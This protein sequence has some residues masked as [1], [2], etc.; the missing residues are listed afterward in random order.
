MVG[1]KLEFR[2]KMLGASDLVL[3]TRGQTAQLVYDTAKAMTESSGSREITLSGGYRI[4]ITT[5]Y[6]PP[7]MTWHLRLLYPYGHIDGPIMSRHATNDVLL[8]AFTYDILEE[9]E[10]L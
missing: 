1:P 3:R 10:R 4:M 5:Q 9:F 8:G 2:Q 7:Q 6:D